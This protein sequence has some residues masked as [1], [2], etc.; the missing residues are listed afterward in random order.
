MTLP[1][2]YMDESHNTGENLLDPQQPV[3][4]LAG[5]HLGD[6]IAQGLL[7]RVAAQLPSGHGELKYSTLSGSHRGRLA[8][9]DAFSGLPAG[10]VRVYI[11]HKKF[12]ATTKMVDTLIVELFYDNGYNMYTDG[13][14]LGLANLMHMVGPVVGDSQSYERVLRLFVDAVRTKK[15]ATVEEFIDSVARYK[16]TV[17]HEE[18]LDVVQLLV[19]ARS[20]ADD[21]ISLVEAGRIRD[22]L[23]PAIPCLRSLC[24]DMAENLGDFILV[25]D[26]SRAVKNN[27]EHLLSL[28]SLPDPVRPDRQMHRL[29]V[30]EIK[31]ADSKSA[32]QLQVADWAAGATRQWGAALVSGVEDKFAVSLSAVVQPWGVGAVWPDPD[33]I[34]NPRLPT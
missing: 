30:K 32:P 1:I 8:L 5:V 22:G 27:V 11:A 24:D 13:S 16:D 12:M 6:D 17:T 10:S 23:D 21:F 2:V 14:A 26:H 19:L 29:P 34:S 20:Q 25:H 18:F 15:R 31:F 28:G 9:L 7:D 4:T 3:F 33:T